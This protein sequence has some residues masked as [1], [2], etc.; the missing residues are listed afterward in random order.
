MAAS[1]EQP[2]YS[3]AWPTNNQFKGYPLHG[4]MLNNN[5]VSKVVHTNWG[6]IDGSIQATPCF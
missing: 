1:T 2:F 5:A 4:G 6:T 3:L